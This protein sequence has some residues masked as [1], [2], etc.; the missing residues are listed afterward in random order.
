MIGIDDLPPSVKIISP[1][2]GIYVKGK[3]IFPAT[4]P[5][6]IG[7][8][9]VEAE[10]KDNDTHITSVAFYFDEKFMKNDSM[11]PYT[12]LMNVNETGMHEIKVIAYDVATNSAIDMKKILIISAKK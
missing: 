4:M 1:K 3:R 10:A 6:I 2:N 12:W 8:V 9:T 5:I 11:P 7:D